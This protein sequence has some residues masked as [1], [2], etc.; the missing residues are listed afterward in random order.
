MGR[1]L[2]EESMTSGDPVVRES[3]GPRFNP[4]PSPIPL[5]WVMMRHVS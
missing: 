5:S 3:K 1:V 2:V 4:G